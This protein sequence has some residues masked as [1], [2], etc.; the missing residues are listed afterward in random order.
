MNWWNPMHMVVDTDGNLSQ[1]RVFSVAGKVAIFKVLLHHMDS[2]ATNPEALLIL[3]AF[4]IMPNVID[5][6]IAARYGAKPN[7][8]ADVIVNK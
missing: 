2:L 8:R 3:L 7:E 5:K 6:V 4:L 1:T